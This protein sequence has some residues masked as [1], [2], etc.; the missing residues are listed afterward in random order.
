MYLLFKR[1]GGDSS[2]PAEAGFGENPNATAARPAAFTALCTASLRDTLCSLSS[3]CITQPSV[4]ARAVARLHIRS[5]T[6][7]LARCTAL[8]VKA[9]ARNT[10]Q[11]SAM[12]FK[13]S[14]LPVSTIGQDSSPGFADSANK[15]L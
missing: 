6:N 12:H 11:S 14:M 15:N 2:S 5:A 10:M 9:A 7:P 3:R 4:Q 8:L 13:C 1:V